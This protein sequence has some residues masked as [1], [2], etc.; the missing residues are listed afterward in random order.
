[1]F[2]TETEAREKVLEAGLELLRSGLIARTW[3][4]I[5]ARISE[6]EFIITPSGRTYES[7]TPD[8]L[9]TVRISD[10]SYAGDV[11][12]SSEKGVH[13]AAYRKR[14]DARFVIHT[15]QEYASALSVLGGVFIVNP[16]RGGSV[17]LGEDVPTARYGLSSTKKLTK[18]VE[19]ALA[20]HPGCRAV[21]MRNH[22]TVCIGRDSEEAFRT[23]RHLERAARRRYFA[24]TGSLYPQEAL[25]GRPL[26]A[27]AEVLHREI[28][29]EFDR[30]YLVFDDPSINVILETEAPFIESVSMSGRTM[31]AYIDDLAQ[32]AGPRIRC[33]EADASDQ[34]IAHAVKGGGAVL[35]EGKGAICAAG[36]EDDAAAMMMVLNK[37]C[38][39]ALLA[40]AGY[41]ALSV[42]VLAGALE[43]QIYRS[44][45]SKLAEDRNA[46]ETDG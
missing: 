6:E 28:H 32:I 42:G 46:E 1:M 16:G 27:Y 25:K 24:M 30:R 39:A 43:H 37:N 19:A 38:M 45:Y 8:D 17:Y 4:N 15:H 22:G 18:N 34:E 40:A 20:E 10:C 21:L 36:S 31:P 29:D 35:I 11:K 5:S 9:V 14:P 23:A 41:K 7:L 12:P 13:A 3:G 26:S 44:S 2:Y 33:L